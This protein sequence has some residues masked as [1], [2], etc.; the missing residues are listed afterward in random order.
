MPY[1]QGIRPMVHAVYIGFLVFSARS[2]D[3][4]Y[5]NLSPIEAMDS[6][7][8]GPTVHTLDSKATQKWDHWNRFSRSQGVSN[9][10]FGD[11]AVESDLNGTFLSFTLEKPERTQM[12][13]IASSWSRL[14]KDTS[15]SRLKKDAS[16]SRL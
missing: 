11:A 2:Q 9:D 12:H 15:W 5:D 3:S 7:M 1:I 14:K 6:D 13:K 10:G 8:G 16:W 4:D